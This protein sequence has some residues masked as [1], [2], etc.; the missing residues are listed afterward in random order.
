[1]GS[2]YEGVL[3]RLQMYRQKR[4]LNQKSMSQMMGVT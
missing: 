1:M 3:Q 2:A 4:K